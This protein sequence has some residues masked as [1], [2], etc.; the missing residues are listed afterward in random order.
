LW[1][2][3]EGAKV[4]LWERLPS[5]DRFHLC[6]RLS[7]SK[8]FFLWRGFQPLNIFFCGRG[9]E[10]SA[11]ILWERLP[12]L[13]DRGRMPLTQVVVQVGSLFFVREASEPRP[14]LRNPKNLVDKQ[15]FCEI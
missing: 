7:A 11:F 6:E 12:S 5:L 2:I 15:S 8:H 13:E 4:F 9:F 1:G 3:E 10:P 14:P